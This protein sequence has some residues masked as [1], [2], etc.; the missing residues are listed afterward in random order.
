MLSV[1]ITLDA[2]DSVAH[3]ITPET[4][5]ILY[6]VRIGHKIYRCTRVSQKFVRT[7]YILITV[8][9]NRY[10]KK[11]QAVLFVLSLK[12]FNDEESSHDVTHGVS[13]QVPKF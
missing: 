8:K 12:I 13:F 6:R 5:T 10:I 7:L 3:S 9:F 2:N 1:P 11:G 4:V